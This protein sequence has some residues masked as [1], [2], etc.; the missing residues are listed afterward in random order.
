MLKD[1]HYYLTSGH[2]P[3]LSKGTEHLKSKVNV[4]QRHFL[5]IPSVLGESDASESENHG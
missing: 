4:L 1:L 3:S 2:N 5:W